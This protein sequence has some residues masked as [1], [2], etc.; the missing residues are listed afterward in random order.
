MSVQ[1]FKNVR[2][3]QAAND[4]NIGNH[5]L[6]VGNLKSTGL[7][8]T[9]IPIIGKNGLLIDTNKFTF[10]FRK[11]NSDVDNHKKDKNSENMRFSSMNKNSENVKEKGVLYVESII[12]SEILSDININGYEI[13]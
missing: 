10:S 1:D 13:R 2:A 11:I 4:L 3:F 12:V 6:S 8:E 7:T 9:R 5:T